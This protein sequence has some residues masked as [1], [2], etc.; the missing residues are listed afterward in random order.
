M[1]SIFDLFFDTDVY[2]QVYVISYSEM[3]ELWRTQNQDELEEIRHQLKK[4]EKASK[5]QV[6]QLDE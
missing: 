1:Y 5:A 4:L 3:K 6:N 2:S